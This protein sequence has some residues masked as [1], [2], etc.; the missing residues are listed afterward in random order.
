MKQTNNAIKFLMAQYRA[1]FKNANIAMVAAMAAAALAAG[2]AQAATVI[3]KWDAG[4]TADDPIVANGTDKL[5][6][7]SG[8][9]VANNTGFDLTI[10]GGDGHVIKGEN[11]QGQ[12]TVANGDNN[13][14]KITVNGADAVLTIGGANNSGA[15]ITI[16]DFANKAGKVVITGKGAES[17]LVATNITIGSAASGEASRAAA[18]EAPAASSAIIEIGASGSIGAAATTEKFNILN[19][20]K[21]LFTKAATATDSKA[22]SKNGITVDGGTIAVEDSGNGLVEGNVKVQAGS[23]E[24]G[25]VKNATSLKVSGDL[26][27]LGGSLSIAENGTLTLAKADSA[28]TLDLSKATVTNSGTID[29]GAI[30][31]ETTAKL[32]MTTAQYDVVFA[33]KVTGSGKHANTHLEVY[34]DGLSL[35]H[36]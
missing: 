30:K 27:F 15:S 1:I 25:G 29:L 26:S 34:V 24:I 5:V 28:P 4:L 20:G 31:N 2:Q 11:A 8:T 21:L 36:I 6:N 32:T 35:I 10:T 33:G 16:K 22:A 23:I 14:G 3:N 17:A 12:F 7:I 13:G 9:A 19:G 18:G